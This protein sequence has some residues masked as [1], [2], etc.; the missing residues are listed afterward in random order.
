MA[1]SDLT[2][3]VLPD[4]KKFHLKHGARLLILVGAIVFAEFL[5]YGD[6]GKNLLTVIQEKQ[7]LSSENWRLR[8]NLKAE[9]RTADDL[10]KRVD[11]QNSSGW[12]E[13]PYSLRRRT[14]KL[15]DELYDFLRERQVNHPP[16]AYPDSSNP[17]PTPEKQNAIKICVAYDQETSDKYMR[18]YSDQLVGIIKE[19]E[20]KGVPTMWLE[21]AAKQRVLYTGNFQG[22]WMPNPNDELYQFRSLA[23][24]VDGRDNRIDL[25]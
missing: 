17:N 9:T 12:K 24:R 23:Y 16:Y 2:N 3:F 15:A 1:L 6:Q 5:A 22:P 11:E 13:S 20:A 8:D 10:R 19:Y 7:Q 25:H 4:Q 21:N 14:I 18:Q